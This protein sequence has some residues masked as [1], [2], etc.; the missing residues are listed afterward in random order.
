MGKP[1]FHS[2]RYV[3]IEWVG[4]ILPTPTA[5]W[6]ASLEPDLIAG[7]HSLSYPLSFLSHYLEKLVRRRLVYLPELARIPSPSATRR[8]QHTID[9]WLIFQ[10]LP[11]KEGVKVKIVSYPQYCRYISCLRLMTL[12]VPM[13]YKVY[14][15]RGG[16]SFSS[17]WPWYLQHFS[18]V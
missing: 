5:E 10:V 6:S 1:M 2:H 14:I 13:S 11:S 8:F 4:L 7:R 9:R 18:Q 17:L 3:T 16:I 15:A 12:G